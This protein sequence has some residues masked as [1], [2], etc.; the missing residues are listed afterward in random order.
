[1]AACCVLHCVSGKLGNWIIWL[2]IVWLNRDSIGSVLWSNFSWFLLIKSV[3]DG[4]G[5][6]QFDFFVQNSINLGIKGE[7]FVRFFIFSWKGPFLSWV[8]LK[9]LHLQL[10][11]QCR[12]RMVKGLM[13]NL[14]IYP[15]LMIKFWQYLLRSWV[16]Q[17]W[18]EM[19]ALSGNQWGHHSLYRAIKHPPNSPPSLAEASKLSNA[20]PSTCDFKKLSSKTPKIDKN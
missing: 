4:P 10:T 19:K 12:V 9:T 11:L 20:P 8:S 16:E 5:S 18:K 7:K 6:E 17:P 1:M 14:C 13:D 15:I 2:A 3:G